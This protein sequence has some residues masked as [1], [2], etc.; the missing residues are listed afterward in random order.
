[1]KKTFLLSLVVILT[2]AITIV[3]FAS[4]TETVV[5]DTTVTVYGPRTSY[6]GIDGDWG[7]G[8]PAMATWEHP[9]WPSIAGATWISTSEYIGDEDDGGSTEDDTWRKFTKTIDLCEGEGAFNISGSIFATSDNAEE[10]YVNGTLVGFDG[11]VQGPFQ[12]NQE[13]NTIQEYFFVAESNTLTFDFIVRN[14]ALDGGTATSN[15]TGLIF[16]VEFTYDCNNPPV[17]DPDGPYLGAVNTNIQFDGSASYDPDNNPLTYMWDFGDGYTGSGET[18]THSYASA[19][20]YDVC[21]TVND[22]FVDSEQVC[23]SAVVYDPT[24][25]FVTG[26]GWIDSPAG[27]VSPIQD[28]AFFNGFETDI[29]GWFTPQRAPSG[30]DGITSSSGDYHAESLDEDFTYWGGYNN[31]FPTGGY[32]TSLDIYLDV[33]AGFDNDTRFDWISAISKPDG[34]HRRDFVFN[35]GFYSDSTG[36]GSGTNRFV[37]SV[38]NN[39]TRSSSYPKNPGHDPIYIDT[40][41]WYT[42]VHR[43]YDNGSGT[44]AVDLRILDASGNLVKKWTLSDPTD[45]IGDTV[46]GNRY[47]WFATN[48]FPFLAIDN[49][50]RTEFAEITGKA[51]FGFVSKYKKGTT[52]PEGNTEFQFNA[53]DLNFHSTYY[54]WLVIT[55]SNYA[56]FKGEGTINGEN[57]PNGNPF[58]FML[59]G[60]DGTGSNGADTFRIKIWYENGGSEF[61]VYD[62]GMDQSIAG[63]NIVVHSK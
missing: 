17:A 8:K 44:L 36:P 29:D 1:M 38:G 18:P 21:L 48:E 40:T 43:F 26:G 14:Y 13:W 33:D 16:K 59:W 55:G 30:T 20:I 25:G 12:D 52:V 62:N 58:K 19:G 49:S 28:I 24:G 2:L 6:A 31:T 56:R 3:A 11:E 53:S 37:I 22:G 47:G 7:I 42:F 61:V 35:T 41:G 50:Y 4:N 46:G 5:S 9:N 45:L 15:P 34:S 23:T 60:G 51:T 54:D 32:Q 63:G 39:A 57:D 10:A 27:A